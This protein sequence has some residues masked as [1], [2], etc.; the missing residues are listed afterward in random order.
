MGKSLIFVIEIG[1]GVMNRLSKILSLFFIVLIF[2]IPRS[3]SAQDAPKISLPEVEWDFGK[4]PKGGIVSHKY[5]IKNQGTKVLRIISVSPGCGCTK[6]PLEKMFVPPNDSTR[7]ELVFNSANF[8]GKSSKGATIVSTD[9]ITGHV[10]INFN[11]EALEDFDSTYPLYFYPCSLTFKPKLTQQE[12]KITNISQEK[13][14]L[15]IVDSADDF[16]QT[17]L[18]QKKLA[19]GKSCNLKIDNKKGLPIEDSFKSITLEVKSD[20]VYRFTLPIRW[21]GWE[22]EN[23]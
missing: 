15:K 21:V 12:I 20:S 18:T 4:I 9:S 3:I 22:G 8:P 11:V 16:Y 6:A 14:E 1:V 10:R 13:L 7:V 5:L 2:S 23:K 19:S 17:R